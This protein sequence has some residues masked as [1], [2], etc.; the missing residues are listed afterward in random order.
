[1]KKYKVILVDR[2]SS[3]RNILEDLLNDGYK[4]LRVDKPSATLDHGYLIYILERNKTK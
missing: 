3:S 4:I 1:M 2:A